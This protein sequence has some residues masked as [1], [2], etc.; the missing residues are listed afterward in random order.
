[1]R[2]TT[3]LLWSVTFLCVLT[4]FS[5]CQK[6]EAVIAS[7]NQEEFSSQ[8]QHVIGER[9]VTQVLEDDHNFPIFASDN[10]AFTEELN[11][12]LTKLVQTVAISVPVVNRNNFAWSVTVIDAP[13]IHMFTAPGGH[14][15]VYTGLLKALGSE[16]E[17][18][19]LMAHEL[20][21]TDQS[22]TILSLKNEF[23]G[24][25]MGDILLGNKV[26]SI[27]NMALWLR[28]LSYSEE[29]VLEADQYALNIICPYLYD[30]KG[31]RNAIMRLDNVAEQTVDWLIRRPGTI[32]RLELLEDVSP[33]DCGSNESDFAD[34]YQSIIAKL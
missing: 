18:I 13:D 14:F 12:Y 1:M 9:L 29:E 2:I 25:A 15:L 22:K 7:K 30:N 20:K 16:A 32:K 28:D 10:T 31:L 3:N 34:R 17:L 19:A 6:E 27:D 5:S 26:S 4:L 11:V 21:Y 24:V 23:G 8:D 33:Q